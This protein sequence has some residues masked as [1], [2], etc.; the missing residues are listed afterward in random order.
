M[1]LKTIGLLGLLAGSI[2]I[3]ACN[4]GGGTGGGAPTVEPGQRGAITLKALPTV[5]VE[6]GIYLTAYVTDW[7]TDFTMNFTASNNNVT[8]VP[9]YC[10]ITYNLYCTVGVVGVAAGTVTIT[11][12]AS[13]PGYIESSI[14]ITVLGN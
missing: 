11:A 1:K 9:S 6:S 2:F 14:V 7:P 10:T 3:S 5:N 12:D 8:L 4:S 13:L